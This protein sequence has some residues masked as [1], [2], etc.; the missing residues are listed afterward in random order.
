MG[1][2]VTGN[3][4]KIVNLGGTACDA[5]SRAIQVE[6]L[7]KQ[8]FTWAFTAD[9]SAITPEFAA[10]FAN[11]LQPI[12]AVF[13]WPLA[14]VPANCVKA[15]GRSLLRAHS[16]AGAGD[17]YPELFAVYGT[18]FGSEDSTHFN[19]RDVRESFLFGA[20]DNHPVGE[21]G[22]E[23]THKLTIPELPKHTFD[24]S[25]QKRV[26]EGNDNAGLLGWVAPMDIVIKSSE[27]GG[28]VPHNNMPPY[29]V[30]TWVIKAR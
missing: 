3:S 4:F 29:A 7:N 1:S 20:G 28:D 9:G 15:D 17:G 18:I 21:D 30:G 27:V 6:N 5:L 23:E 22:G 26:A 11:Y 10:L 25:L 2:P 13:W 14:S 12:G 8:F 24:I 19:V 16:S